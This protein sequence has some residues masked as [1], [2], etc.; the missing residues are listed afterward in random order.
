MRVVIGSGCPP[1]SIFSVASGVKLHG[2]GAVGASQQGYHVSLSDDGS[3][4]AVGG[5]GDHG[6]IGAV[7]IS[8]HDS[9]SGN[10]TQQGSKLVGSRASGGASQGTSACLSGDGTTLALGGQTDDASTG[11]T[12]IFALNISSGNWTQR[13]N[14]LVGSGAV[15]P[16]SQGR[17]VALSSDGST[18]AVGGYGDNSSVGAAWVFILNASSG[19][20][21][22]Q[23]VKLNAT[24]AIGSARQGY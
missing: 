13:G 16:S 8:T 10:W 6:N 5:P 9:S 17:S 1:G 20:W 7:W 15:G 3:T 12:W 19:N 21:T 23:G 4:L 14:K 24:D 2:S 18:L 11:A 22:Q